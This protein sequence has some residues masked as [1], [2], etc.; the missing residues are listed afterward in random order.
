METVNELTK[1]ISKL[2]DTPTT[3]P[4]SVSAHTPAAELQS[5]SGTPATEPQSVSAHTPA[6]EP[7]SVSAQLPTAQPLANPF[8]V[9]SAQIA[10]LLESV[11]APNKKIEEVEKAAGQHT[12][13]GQ[14][15]KDSAQAGQQAMA[16]ASGPVGQ[17]PVQFPQAPTQK[18]ENSDTF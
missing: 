6:T 12:N 2:K 3:E 14:Q 17:A 9:Q 11:K 13:A 8:Q 15:A 10:T 16:S 1:E 4:Q 7:Q 18:V 5:V